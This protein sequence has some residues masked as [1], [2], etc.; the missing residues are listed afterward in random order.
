MLIYVLFFLI[1]IM[2]VGYYLKGNRDIFSPEVLFL[3]SYTVSIGSAL[4]N[5]KK[6]G[7]VMHPIT[8]LVLFIGTIEFVVICYIVNR[9]FKK[10]YNVNI[11]QSEKYSSNE[12]HVKAWKCILTYLGCVMCSVL[13]FRTVLGIAAN[14]GGYSTLPQAFQTFKDALGEMKATVPGIVMQMERIAMICAYVFT[15]IFINNV[16]VK[17]DNKVRAVIRNIHLLIPA[18]LYNI[19]GVINSDRLQIIQYVISVIVMTFILWCYNTGKS[20]VSIKTIIILIVCAVAGLL[21]FYFSIG[22]LGRITDKNLIEYIT[23]YCGCSIE[24]LNQFLQYPPESSNIFGKET[25]YNFNYKLYNMGLLKLDDGFYSIHLEQRYYNDIFIGNVYTSY[26][27]WIYDFGFGGAFILQGIMALFMSVFYNL[28]KYRKA[29]SC[30]LIIYC[31]LAYTAVFHAYDGYLYIQYVSFT[32]LVS[33]FL[34]IL[35]YL[36]F[37]KYNYSVKEWRKIIQDF[38]NKKVKKS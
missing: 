16:F 24:D 34:F 37:I 29:N 19:N 8:F 25:F 1:L 23:L 12:I 36:F 10:K 33:L 13:L 9:Y 27:R 22:L 15:F 5:V 7:I 2:L 35:A 14:N 4:V 28:V 18:V 6:W 20:F 38:V 11:G 26:R 30:C 3:I 31:Y 32:F 17:D 21:V